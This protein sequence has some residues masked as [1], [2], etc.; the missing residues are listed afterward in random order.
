MGTVHCLSLEEAEVAGAALSSVIIIAGPHTL[1]HSM[2]LGPRDTAGPDHPDHHGLG[3]IS[4][5]QVEPDA[6][7]PAACLR[8]HRSH[9]TG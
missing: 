5:P 7:P 2:A 8:H 4:W 3:D 6:T 1:G 9:L